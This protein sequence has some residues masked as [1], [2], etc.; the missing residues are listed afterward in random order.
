MQL[1]DYDLIIQTLGGAIIAII[2]NV[3]KVH[4]DLQV[5]KMRL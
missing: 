4:G 3:A 1:L 5:V 2:S